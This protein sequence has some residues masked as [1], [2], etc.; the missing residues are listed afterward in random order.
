MEPIREFSDPR[1]VR[2]IGLII[3]RSYLKRQH[4]E[5]FKQEL[6]ANIPP[7]MQTSGNDNLIEWT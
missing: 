3:H 2:E 4:I 1:P 7:A 6:L 5:L